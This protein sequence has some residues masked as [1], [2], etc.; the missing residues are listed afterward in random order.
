MV[1][2]DAGDEMLWGA[3]AQV[4]WPFVPPPLALFLSAASVGF[5]SIVLYIHFYK[6][7]V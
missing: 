5:V 7:A 1:Y 6:P 4:P 2:V 3:A